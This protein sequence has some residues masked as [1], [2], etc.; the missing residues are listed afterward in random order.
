VYA[1]MRLQLVAYQRA[2]F[3]ARIGDAERHPVPPIERCGILHVTDS[4]TRLFPAD[5]TEDDWTTFRACLW[6]HGWKG[7]S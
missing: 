2:E 5:V 3:I 6:I 7:R 1:D 4:G